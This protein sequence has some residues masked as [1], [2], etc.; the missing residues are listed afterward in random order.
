[1][2]VFRCFI[3]ISLHDDQH[4][5]RLKIL[6]PSKDYQARAYDAIVYSDKQ[7]DGIQV[8]IDAAT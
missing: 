7:V 8:N 4:S 2:Y 1:M 3:V 6:N 5:V